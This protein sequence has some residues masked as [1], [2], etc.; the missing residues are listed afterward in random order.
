MSDQQHG[1]IRPGVCI[2]WEQRRK[3]YP[4]IMGDEKV[5]QKV[6]EQIDDLAYSYIWF[7][8]ILF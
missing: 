6:W 1:P 2:P 5:V 7:C 3:E 8:L 4:R